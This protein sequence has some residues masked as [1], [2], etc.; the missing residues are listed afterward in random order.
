MA[1]MF[2]KTDRELEAALQDR[3][4]G[5]SAKIGVIGLGYVG[6][7]L[8]IQFA[9]K[10]FPV[11]GFDI[12]PQKVKSLQSGKSYIK[13]IDDEK[14]QGLL[15]LGTFTSVTDFSQLAKVDC[16]LICVPTPLTRNREPDLSYLINTG[17]TISK[18]R[19]KGQL[20]VLESTTYPGT[21]DEDLRLILEESGLKAG[22]DF[23][24]AYSPEREDPNNAFFSIE[25]TPK[26]VGGYTG[27]CL[28]V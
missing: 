18:Y 16:L 1:K 12:D 14:I 2:N 24:L 6:L 28:E 5:K 4:R 13:H 3:I 10:G 11:T 26:V 22:K 9:K 23:Y 27:A 7:P 8:V 25:T 19:R 15:D 17:K 21:T 20:V